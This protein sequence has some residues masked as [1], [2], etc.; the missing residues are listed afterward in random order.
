ME[1]QEE[2]TFTVELFPNVLP[3]FLVLKNVYQQSLV[4]YEQ[5]IEEDKIIEQL[6]KARCRNINKIRV[7]DIVQREPT[8]FPD[9][10]WETI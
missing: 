9:T 10:N 7:V 3:D 1:A 8:F 2:L 5:L 4:R 6:F